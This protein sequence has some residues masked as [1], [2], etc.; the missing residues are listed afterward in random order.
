MS[1]RDRGEA[2]LPHF[3]STDPESLVYSSDQSGNLLCEITANQNDRKPGKAKTRLGKDSHELTW[4]CPALGGQCRE[5]ISTT[6]I[7][8]PLTR[9]FN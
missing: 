9:F 8:S 2:R 7:F 5:E 4:H 3:D 6:F 1:I